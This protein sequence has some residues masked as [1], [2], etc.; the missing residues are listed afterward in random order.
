MYKFKTEDAY[1]FKEHVGIRAK[2]VGDELVFRECP[3][4]RSSKDRDTFS[5]S[6]MTGQ[7]ECKRA[8]CAR[9]GNMIT[10]AQE[11]DGFSLGTDTD[12]YYGIRR[13]QYRKPFKHDYVERDEAIAYLSSRGISRET[14]ERY[15]ITVQK[16]AKNILVFPFMNPDGLIETVKY[17]KTDFDKDKDKNKEWFM[18]GC[19]PI[20]FGM[21]QCV[22]TSRLVITEGQMDS[23][24]L[25]E[26]YIQ[27]AVSVPNGANGFTWIPYCW[28]WINQFDQIIVFGDCEHGS[29]TLVDEIAK[30]FRKKDV[31][32][33]REDD[34]LGCK[35]ANEILQKHGA[36][37]L[38]R[39]VANA[40]MVYTGNIIEMADVGNISIEDMPAVRTTYPTVDKVL[41][42]GIHMGQ[43]VVL[44]GKRGNGK[45]TFASKLLCEAIE[46]GFKTFI[47]SG[48]LINEN[49]KKWFMQQL[50]GLP[51]VS[52]QKRAKADAWIRGKA[53]M[54]DCNQIDDEA[55]DVPDLIEMSICK[56]GCQFI[57]VDNLMTSM[58]YTAGDFYNKQ[59][60]FVRKLASLAK[61]YKVAVVLV[62][63][64]RKG[65]TTGAE[66]D[67]ISGS[68]NITDRADIVMC[69]QRDPKDDDQNHRLLSISKNRLTGNLAVK[70]DA[71]KFIYNPNSRRM[72][73]HEA[74]LSVKYGWMDAED[75][76]VQEGEDNLEVP[77]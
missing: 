10:L 1:A 34:Y 66:N 8:S 32:A 9:V 71:I 7:F 22:N 39:A 62:A 26:A 56:Y 55:T 2:R 4:C 75:E 36:K 14:A 13:E 76:W 21:Y 23:L 11:F 37:A 16:D 28:D 3:F 6:L 30:R 53:F 60:E 20:L 12:R 52:A 40:K 47:Y 63:H 51:E 43:L 77:F 24:S 38:R 29:I 58:S 45:S 31:R 54:Y 68:S 17:R 49:V 5:I 15:R 67:D 70:D 18:K 61:R 25:S 69:Y 57:V 73:E 72:A 50:T 74:G 19:K 33:I 35:D 65:D 46:Q 42:G 41:S 27:N 44:T 48:E 59:S 64:P